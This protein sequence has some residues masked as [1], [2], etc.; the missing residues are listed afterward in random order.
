MDPRVHGVAHTR[1]EVPVLADLLLVVLVVQCVGRVDPD[2]E[3]VS[4]G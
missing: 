3:G 4:L 2:G 1:H